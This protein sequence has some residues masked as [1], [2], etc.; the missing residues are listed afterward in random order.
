MTAMSILAMM[1]AF[2]NMK[3][4]TS[5]LEKR[6]EL[7]EAISTFPKKASIRVSKELL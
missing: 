5:T 7:I 6:S 2:T 1:R 4:M 3:K